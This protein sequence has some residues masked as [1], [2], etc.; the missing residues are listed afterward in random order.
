MDLTR[1]VLWGLSG[2]I[3]A[4]KPWGSVGFII[5]GAVFVIIALIDNYLKQKYFDSYMKIDGFSVLGA[6]TI[7]MTGL[8]IW[9]DS[10][11]QAGNKI[12]GFWI[13]VFFFIIWLI[14]VFSVDREISI[15]RS[16]WRK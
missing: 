15:I 6:S 8:I 10:Y 14:V 2:A 4:L 16:K 3:F 5:G 1:Y 11:Q 12:S 13:D 7:F 9:A